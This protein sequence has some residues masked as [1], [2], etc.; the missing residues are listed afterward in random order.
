VILFDNQGPVEV[1]VT[2]SIVV[3]LALLGLVGWIFW[4]A[5]HDD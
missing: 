1:I 4:R 3:P 2:L 5:R